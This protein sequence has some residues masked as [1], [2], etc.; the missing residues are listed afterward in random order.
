MQPFAATESLKSL[1]RI[2]TVAPFCSVLQPDPVVGLPRELET[3][4]L[5]KSLNMMIVE[6]KRI[7]LSKKFW[8]QFLQGL[9]TLNRYWLCPQLSCLSWKGPK[10]RFE[11][12]VLSHPIKHGH[13]FAQ[14]EIRVQ[15]SEDLA[16]LN[17][18]IGQEIYV[19]LFD[20]G[21]VP[22]SMYVAY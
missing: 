16:K 9:R 1:E 3:N 13:F 8:G 12:F 11:Y 4:H 21:L 14:F 10:R 19:T 5:A 20:R 7:K 6:T 17:E 15:S 22:P 2:V 18:E